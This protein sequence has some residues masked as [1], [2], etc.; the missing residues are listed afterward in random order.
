MRRLLLLAL[1]AGPLVGC[2]GRETLLLDHRSGTTG[3][4][5]CTTVRDPFGGAGLVITGEFIG[6]GHNKT[7]FLNKDGFFVVPPEWRGSVVLRIA[8]RGSRKLRI[9]L[10]SERGKLKSYRP[11]LPAE[12]RWCEVVLPLRHISSTIR[13]GE[14]IVDIT[15]WQVE[16]DKEGALYVD[17]A[18]LRVD[19]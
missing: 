18:L 9:A 16:S 7:T 13:P 1:A 8:V 11:E 12:G 15:I 19:H 5:H 4:P 3:R 6:D 17:R 10:V 14:K 2:A